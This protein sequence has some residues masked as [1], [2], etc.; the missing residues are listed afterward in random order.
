MPYRLNDE[1]SQLQAQIVNA[2]VE[3]RKVQ[4][5]ALAAASPEFR[6]ALEDIVSS[7]MQ[8]LIALETLFNAKRAEARRASQPKSL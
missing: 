6:A 2:R 7:H 1:C 8:R 3:L 4:D 5:A